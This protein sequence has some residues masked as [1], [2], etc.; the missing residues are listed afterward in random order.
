MNKLMH[1]A[2]VAVAVFM[3]AVAAFAAF[4]WTV[5]GLSAAKMAIEQVGLPAW[6]VLAFVALTAITCAVG[7]E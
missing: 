7:G 1:K 5:L 3:I 4:G 2:T 6:P